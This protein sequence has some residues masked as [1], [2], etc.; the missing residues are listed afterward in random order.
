MHRRGSP[1]H[2]VG[3]LGIDRWGGRERVQMRVLDA[4]APA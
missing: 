2:V 4:A 3:T 1:V